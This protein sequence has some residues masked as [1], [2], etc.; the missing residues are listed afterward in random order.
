MVPPRLRR[1]LCIAAVAVAVIAPAK[2]SAA[3]MI[4]HAFMAD[5]AVERVETPELQ[6]FLIAHHHELLSGASFPDGG[7]FAGGYGEISH[8][9]RFINA[10]IAYLRERPGCGD[11]ADPLGPCAT[12][13][14]HM[15]GAGAHGMGDETWDWMFEPLVAD[16]GE[17]PDHPLAPPEINDVIGSIAYA[18]DTIALVDYFRWGES[19]YFLPPPNELTPIYASIGYGEITEDDLLAG[20]AAGSAALAL[21]RAGG[22]ADSE[23]V[24]EQMPWSAANFYG[25]SGGV[26]YSASAIA[27]YYEALWAKLL[28][29]EPPPPRVIAIHPANGEIGVPFEFHPAKTSPGPDTG[30]GELRI[31]AVLSNAVDTASVTPDSF[32]LLGPDGGAVPPLDGFPR[33]GPYGNG[34][35]THSVMTYPASDLEPCTTYTAVATTGLRDW[36][37][38]PVNEGKA[39]EEE[40][41]W[42]FTTRSADG[43]P[44]PPPP[45]DPP[46]PDEPPPLDDPPPPDRPVPPALR[47][48]G[49]RASV[50]PAAGEQAGATLPG[51]P[52]RDVIVGSA[53]DDVIAA[54]RGD[55]IV[56]AGGG[57]DTIQGGAGDD[58]I[59]ADAGD[60]DVG[61]SPG[62]DLIRA[63]KG[64]D[65]VA[66]GAGDDRLHGGAG[67]D[68]QLGAAGDD[69][70]RGKGGRDALA[71]GAGV[72]R[73]NGGQGPADS[74]DGC[75]RVVGVP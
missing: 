16:H 18:M 59:S 41:R 64:A 32:K 9:E 19:G 68:H 58:L 30:G 65:E 17:V 10:Y 54:G 20:H 36:A 22:V 48:Q 34:D 75:E 47:C 1:A 60:D 7:Y 3:G 28:E 39:L 62:N 53:G 15:L 6:S 45:D 52:G 38:L 24:R 61:G 57:D 2:A 50:Y 70:L 74:A 33:P 8:W 69:R 35:G 73:C 29:P 49:L 46:P 21:E 71:G 44:C 4:T 26:V 12:L 37:E 63:N 13:V 67:D 55:D 5:E 11:L 43:E 40:V 56:C 14:A 51:T 66:G 27:G 72:D 25:E 42:S 23:R 31:I